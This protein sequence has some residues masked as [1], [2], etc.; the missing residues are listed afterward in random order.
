M[1]Q[2]ILDTFERGHELHFLLAAYAMVMC[3]I[4]PS[5]SRKGVSSN[6]RGANGAM[7]QTRR[8]SPIFSLLLL[9]LLLLLRTMILVLHLLTS[10]SIGLHLGLPSTPVEGKAFGGTGFVVS[11]GLRS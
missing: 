10:F 6:R 11:A 8:V 1:Y 4:T 3:S 2:I 7:L 9:L 5:T